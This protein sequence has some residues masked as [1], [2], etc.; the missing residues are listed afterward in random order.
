MAI[1]PETL[2]KFLMN[3]KEMHG[4]FCINFIPAYYVPDYDKGYEIIID[5]VEQLEKVI[6]KYVAAQLK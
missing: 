3:K 5:S 1:C 2:L 4:E 6:N